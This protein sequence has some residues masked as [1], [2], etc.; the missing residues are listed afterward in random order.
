[1]IS[2]VEVLVLVVIIGTL[3]FKRLYEETYTHRLER[4]ILRVFAD[5]EYPFDGEEEDDRL[6]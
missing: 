3:L 4:R 5:D 1:M 6:H 2:H